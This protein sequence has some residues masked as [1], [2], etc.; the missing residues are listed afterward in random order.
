MGNFL[1][2]SQFRMHCLV[3]FLA[4]SYLGPA[5][6]RLSFRT[7]GPLLQEQDVE[8][9]REF[10]PFGQAAVPKGQQPLT[11][12]K[13]LRRQ[14]FY[15]WAE[16]DA[17]KSKVTQVYQFIM[18]FISLPVSYATFD[19]LP[20]ELPQLF[21]AANIGTFAVMLPF[22]ARLRV[23][24]GYVSERLKERKTYYEANQRGLFATKDREMQLRDRLIQ[25]QEVH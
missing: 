7:R 8:V 9:K 6:Q 21:L 17:Y 18:L 12:L 14:P 15:D 2:T 5:P 19:Q 11:E 3:A 1:A 13:E 24:W 22:I 10:N 23:G 4:T 16:S 20:N 25:Q